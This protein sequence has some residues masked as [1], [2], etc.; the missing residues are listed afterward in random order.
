MKL[1]LAVFAFAAIFGCIR[2]DCRHHNAIFKSVLATDHECSIYLREQTTCDGEDCTV[3]CRGLLT[4]YWNDSVGVPSA[5][6][7]R[8]YRPS[9]L[10]LG[11][12]ER[13]GCCLREVIARVPQR[14]VC[15]R[16]DATIGCFNQHYGHFRVK[17]P[18]FVP[19]TDLQHQQI[20]REC[21]DV[22]RIPHTIIAGYLKH[23]IEHYPEA[24]CL[25]RCFLIREGL[26]TD[27]GGPD[28][29]RMSVQCEGNYSDEQFRKKASK[30]IGKLQ[31]QCLDKCE[32]AFRICDECVTGEVQ[33]LSVFVG[34]SKSTSNSITVSP[35]RTVIL[36]PTVN[37]EAG[38]VFAPRPA[39]G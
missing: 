3:R 28:L 36:P 10:D 22:L 39:A 8:F 17:S 38:S 23:G 6:I 5:T 16:A 37:V 13:T 12:S 26:Y 2:A 21:I 33:L 27:A 35:S 14:A 24:Q 15:R 4:R 7:N 20:L 1:I 11:Y 31:Q 19:F 18:K 30:C 32:L 25:L 9:V 29:Y 34:A